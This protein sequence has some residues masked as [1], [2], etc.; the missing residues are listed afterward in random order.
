M[1]STYYIA[2]ITI[3]NIIAP[4]LSFTLNFFIFF[5]KNNIFSSKAKHTL[6][7]NMAFSLSFIA[8]LYKRTNDTGDLVRYIDEFK[9][10][11]HAPSI[12][13]NLFNAPLWYNTLYYTKLLGLTINWVSFIVIFSSLYNIFKIFNF[14]DKY[15]YKHALE[16]V[17]FKLFVFYGFFGLLSS[18]RNF[19]AATFV[20]L[21]IIYIIQVKRT[22]GLSLFLI[23]F[24][25]HPSVIL[26]IIIF[27]LSKVMNFKKIY[28]LYSLII[29]SV[30][31]LIILALSQVNFPIIDY[32]IGGYVE[33]DWANY[34]FSEPIELA[35]F[36][37]CILFLV[38]LSSC[39]IFD[40]VK[41]D[42]TS[43]NFKNYYNFVGFYVCL[44]ISF[45]NLRTFFFRLT[46]MGFIFTIPFLFEVFRQRKIFSKSST[47]FIIL[48]IWYLMIDLSDFNIFN[49]SYIVGYGFP[50]NLIQSPLSELL[51]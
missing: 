33:G 8:Y 34:N 19:W 17:Y 6:R 10:I 16:H 20:A 15:N 12:I 1:R 32:V 18:Y 3:L 4:I 51:K 50:M 24:L 47:S 46:I 23:G 29:S 27:F 35:I 37:Q 38:F 40:F 49:N 45:I 26:P 41:N 42:N 7:L 14:L 48:I 5:L 39:I 43:Y 13:L 22:K 9:G 25:I 11:S 30:T 2:I 44:C 28:L 36:I 21:G 31:T